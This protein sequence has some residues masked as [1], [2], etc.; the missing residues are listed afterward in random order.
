MDAFSSVVTVHTQYKK[1][2]KNKKQN[3]EN[4]NREIL[5]REG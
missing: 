5:G 4:L 3:I 1:T 2:N